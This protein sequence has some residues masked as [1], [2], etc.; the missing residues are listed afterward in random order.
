MTHR[1][2]T[3]LLIVALTPLLGGTAAAQTN[4]DGSVYSRYGLGTLEPA[5]TSQ[6]RAMGRAETALMSANYV[7]FSNPGAWSAQILTRFSGS[8]NYQSVR[9][10]N[11]AGETSQ[12]TTSQLGPASFTFPILRNRLGFALLYNPFTRIGYRIRDGGTVS[13]DTTEF[14]GTFSGDGGLQSIRTGL[15]YRLSSAIRVGASF[16]LITGILERGRFIRYPGENY[17]D[18]RITHETQLTGVTGTLGALVTAPDL[19]REDDLFKFGGS[20]RLPATLDGTRLNTLGETLDR[21]T[22]GTVREGSVE[23]PAE[24]RGGIAYRPNEYWHIAVDG[25]YEPWTQFESELSFAGYTPGPNGS[26]RFTD[27]W[28]V[29]GGFEYVPAG[30]AQNAPYLS[31]TAYRLGG[32]VDR[33]YVQPVS[34]VDLTTYALT[35]GLGLPT[36]VAGNHLDVSLEVG[37]RGTTSQGLV[38]DLYFDLS[39]VLNF[40][41]RWF[42]EQAIQ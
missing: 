8:F 33:H 36:A 35:A 4:N 9:Y 37:S 14:T 1:F 28:Q 39:L 15:G 18:A 24:F 7:P 29:G 31:R 5:L 20:V 19:F 2:R 23:L 22:V 34:G 17:A 42:M 41:E 21:D 40:G 12:L 16:D 10:R 26:S 13:G 11:E 30:T 32:L 3:L 25:V 27:R 38:R 6:A